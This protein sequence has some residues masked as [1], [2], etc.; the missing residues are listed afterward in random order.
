MERIIKDRFIVRWK[1]GCANHKLEGITPLFDA[2]GCPVPCLRE[3][4]PGEDGYDV[5]KDLLAQC[6][7]TGTTGDPPQTGIQPGGGGLTKRGCVYNEAF[8]PTCPEKPRTLKGCVYDHITED[9]DGIQIISQI[10]SP[11]DTTQPSIFDYDG[12]SQGPLAPC[13]SITNELE[14]KCTPF[15]QSYKGDTIPENL[16]INSFSV[17]VPKCCAI[18]VVT[19]VGE[20]EIGPF[21]HMTAVSPCKFDCA[22]VITDVVIVSGK[23]TKADICLTLQ[24]T[25]DLLPTSP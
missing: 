23:C 10:F 21:P 11:T 9:E 15:I 12:A 14:G 20:M 13:V 17:Q 4:C 7:L 19:S 3:Y 25:G 22:I 8:D 5:W 24:N 1:K 2:N 16:P 6:I 18:K